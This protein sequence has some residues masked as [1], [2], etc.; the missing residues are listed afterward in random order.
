MFLLD[1]N[2][3]S[4]L[5]K[6]RSGKADVYVAAWADSVDA[7]DLYLS[8]IAAQARRSASCGPYA[9]DPAQGAVLRARPS[10]HVPAASAGLILAVDAVVAQ[11][12]ARPSVGPPPCGRAHRG[13]G[14]R[15][16][17]DDRH[18]QRDRLHAHG[19][20]TLDGGPPLRRKLTA[21]KK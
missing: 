11:R 13:N 14:T 4:E 7:A 19:V 3:V 21:R 6:V 10:G 2:V 5:R 15:A 9:A 17:H 16:R 12:S 8:V 1:T 20:P 18:A